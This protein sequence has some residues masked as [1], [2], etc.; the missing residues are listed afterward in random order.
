MSLESA[1]RTVLECYPAAGEIAF[2]LGNRGGFSGARLWRAEGLA[3]PLCLRAWPIG[4][5]EP[6]RLRW[7][8]QLMARAGR[9]GLDYVPVVFR[10]RDGQS[11]MEHA[12]RLWE[13]TAWM[14]GQADFRQRPSV[15]RL[16]S[17]CLAL[18]RLHQVWAR[19]GGTSGPCPA[20]VQRL[21]CVGEW[22][23]L[24]GSGWRPEFPSEDVDPVT[25]LAR[26]AWQLVERH[27]DTIEP[28][29]ARRL[30][31]PMRLQPC[32]C[33]IWH[34]HVLFRGDTVSG[35]VDYGSTKI[36]H[37]AADLARLLGSLVG[38][39][40]TLWQVGLRAYRECCDLTV[41]EE[42]LVTC[43]DHSGTILAAANW[44][45]WLYYEQRQFDDRR[46]VAERLAEIVTRLETWPL[47]QPGAPA[48]GDLS[49]R[50]TINPP[51]AGAPG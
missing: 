21:A 1:A 45:R 16:R 43:L 23:K 25:P 11:F 7:I 48:T 15:S 51:A 49:F 31:Q 14:P 47:Y 2:A 19:A 30:D 4:G 8:H 20:V 17:A 44:L 22:R 28:Q 37:V 9:A 36:N 18:A 35:L 29:L 13:L 42:E 39:N 33:D 12:G 32:L 24:I 46:A 6:E 40:A 5:P 50:E 10:T 26:R 3:G 34:A 27:V 38:E 41:E